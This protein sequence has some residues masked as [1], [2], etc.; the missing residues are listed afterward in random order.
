MRNTTRSG[1]IQT[2][3][4]AAGR[5]ALVAG[6]AALQIPAN[7]A[8]LT[9]I[10]DMGSVL[11]SPQ[12]VQPQVVFD[13]HAALPQNG[14]FSAP[15]Q[16][17]AAAYSFTFAD[18]ADTPVAF[19]P[20]ATP[21][22][23]SGNDYFDGQYVR[24]DYLRDS[25]TLMMDPNEVVNVSW[26]GQVIAAGS[27]NFTDA[28]PVF[29]G[30]VLDLQV[31]YVHHI[32][33]IPVGG[34]L[35]I[36][37]PVLG[38]LSYYSNAYDDPFGW[39]GE[40]TISQALDSSMLSDLSQDGVVKFDAFALAGDLHFQSASLQLTIEPGPAAIPEPTPL[41]LVAVGFGALWVLRRREAGPLPG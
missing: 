16:I 5:V 23:Q 30:Q 4:S 38:L 27:S 9:L 25:T 2:L 8:V 28:S 11:L 34:G 1:W 21:Y 15:Y 12:G 36:P 29:I 39:G 24:T 41:P 22:V 26:N 33:F 17:V 6:L 14:N 40:F 32:D 31:P 13:I 35:S 3:A 20:I 7:A 10:Q 19:G 37:V 18:N